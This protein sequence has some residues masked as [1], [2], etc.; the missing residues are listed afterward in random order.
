MG[1]RTKWTSDIPILPQKKI[2]NEDKTTPPGGFFC[3]GG[4]KNII[5]LCLTMPRIE[6]LV[7]CSSTGAIPE[8]PKGIAIKEI[9]YFDETK[10][11][12]CYAMSKA[13]GSQEV[14]DA[15]H[16]RGL[17]ACI[18]HPSGIMGRGTMLAER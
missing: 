3:V 11:P 1:S 8:Q 7:Y 17:N 13:M 5:E 15:C 4:T 9:D 16:H 10:V 18:V 12:G 6:K 2:T 14:L